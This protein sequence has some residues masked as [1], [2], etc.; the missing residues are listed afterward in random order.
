MTEAAGKPKLTPIRWIFS[1]IAVLIMLLAVT[2]LLIMIA[3][4]ILEWKWW[5]VIVG[6]ETAVLFG[7]IPFLVGLFVWFLAVKVGR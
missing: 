3:G 5:H 4:V 6:P 2:S 7:V 1:G